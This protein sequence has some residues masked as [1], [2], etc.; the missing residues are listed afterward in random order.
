ME[1]AAEQVAHADV[2]RLPKHKMTAAATSRIFPNAGTT[3]VVV[4]PVDNATMFFEEF[5]PVR[6]VSGAATQLPRAWFQID[7]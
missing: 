7:R 3:P 1:P 6:A 4:A 2:L 5:L